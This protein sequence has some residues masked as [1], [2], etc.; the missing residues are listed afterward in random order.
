MKTMVNG[1]HSKYQKF[2]E[3]ELKWKLPKNGDHFYFI[4]LALLYFL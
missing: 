1:F 2:L 4:F 3:W